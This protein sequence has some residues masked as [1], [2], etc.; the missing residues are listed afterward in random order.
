VPQE[1]RYSL[2][3]QVKATLEDKTY[4]HP[5]PRV[6]R[7]KII[8]RRT[9]ANGLPVYRI[10]PDGG[11]RACEAG[12]QDIQPVPPEDTRPFRE[13]LMSA[14]ENLEEKPNNP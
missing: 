5:T 12:E 10:W 8:G 11:K 4:V 13:R 7:G 3:Q 14:G 2:G 6:I 1:Y 9:P